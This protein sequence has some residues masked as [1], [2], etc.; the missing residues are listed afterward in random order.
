MKL[1]TK[2][3]LNNTIRSC[4]TI[5]TKSE[6]Q[7]GK[8]STFFKEPINKEWK[9]DYIRNYKGQLYDKSGM[10]NIISHDVNEY[11]V[12]VINHLQFGI[13]H[14]FVDLI[15][16]LFKEY[17]RKTC[18]VAALRILKKKT[19]TST[20]GFSFQ[21]S[22]KDIFLAELDRKP[23]MEANIDLILQSDKIDGFIIHFLR[24]F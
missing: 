8:P 2:A 12:N 23:T 7:R 17:D 5:H 20:E 9:Q 19:G 16:Y 13:R 3:Q 10:T 6:D 15:K 22:E 14:H 4:Y 21:L 11:T 24:D 1:E 18:E